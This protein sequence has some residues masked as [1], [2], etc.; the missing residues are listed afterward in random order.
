MPTKWKKFLSY[1]QRPIA[2]VARWLGGSEKKRRR[3]NHGGELPF[4]FRP[5]RAFAK[6][7]IRNLD[8]PAQQPAKFFSPAGANS[9][10]DE[11]CCCEAAGGLSEGGFEEDEIPEIVAAVHGDRGCEPLHPQNGLQSETAYGTL[12]LEIRNL[13]AISLANGVILIF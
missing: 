9:D 2:V 5:I 6:R 13:V 7:P 12:C 8:N 11:C 3:A 4:A 10:H 1:M